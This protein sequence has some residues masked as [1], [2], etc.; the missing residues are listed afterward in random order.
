MT[1]V[2]QHRTRVEIH[3]DS[4]G[5][6]VEL[7]AKD[8]GISTRKLSRLSLV[9]AGDVENLVYLNKIPSPM[10]VASLFRIFEVL[11]LSTDEVVAALLKFRSKK[12]KGMD[13]RFHFI[14]R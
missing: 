11:D 2:F 12:I 4:L 8:K 5:Q 10:Q 6:F 1:E 13:S 9:P 14:K 3:G 7:R